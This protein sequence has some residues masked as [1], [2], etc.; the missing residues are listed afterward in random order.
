MLDRE[1][2]MRVRPVARSAA[3]LASV[4]PDVN[5]TRAGDTPASAATSARASSTTR[6]ARRPKP[7][8]EDGLPATSKAA[9]TASRTSG[10]IGAVAL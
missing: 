1:T 7:W 3:V 5:T 4:P 10:R 2:R 8:T 9:M 6:R